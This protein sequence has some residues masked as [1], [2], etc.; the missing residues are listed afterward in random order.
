VLNAALPTAARLITYTDAMAFG[1]HTDRPCDLI[2]CDPP[3]GLNA[4]HDT[5][6]LARLYQTV[7]ERIVQA[8]RDGGQLVLAVP[9]WS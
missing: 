1:T 7:L 9:D 8:L 2:I 3:Y 5:E 4:E 6:G